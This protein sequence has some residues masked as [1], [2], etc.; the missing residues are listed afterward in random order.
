MKDLQF[1]TELR[2]I[3][4]NF[5]PGKIPPNLLQGEA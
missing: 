5:A 3:T 2:Q 1:A 4:F